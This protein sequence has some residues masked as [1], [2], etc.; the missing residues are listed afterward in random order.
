MQD[1]DRLVTIIF[2]VGVAGY[3]VYTGWKARKTGGGLA[4]AGAVLL[5]GACLA[6][7][8]VLAVFGG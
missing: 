8:V 5:A 3:K 2:G 1:W 4:L 7:P 6:L